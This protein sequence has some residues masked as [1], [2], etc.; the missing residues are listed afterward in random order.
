MLFLCACQKSPPV[1]APLPKPPGEAA[2]GR[3]T[4][5]TE[6]EKRLGIPDGLTRLATSRSSQRRL[7]RG[8][9]IPPPGRSAWLLAPH[10][11]FVLPTGGSSLPHASDHVQSGQVMAMLSASL[12]PTERAQISTVRVDADAQVARA[13][14]QD[15]ASELALRR[16]E[17][18]LAEDAVGTKVV[19]EAQAQ[20]DTAR[21]ALKAALA[22]QAAVVGS[23]EV[24]SQSSATPRSVLSQIQLVAPLSGRVRDVKVAARQ[25]VLAGTPLFEIVD[26]EVAWVRVSVPA[27]MI[28][29][30]PASTAAYVDAL[31]AS[32]KS[33]AV[34]APPAKQAPAT[35]NPPQATV[36]RY[37]V[38]P[39]T[40]RFQIGQSVAVWLA[41]SE[42]EESPTVQAAALL[43]DASGGTWVYQQAAPY[44]F[45]RRRV[46]VVRI[47]EG[48]ALLSNRSL[49][50][51]GLRIGDRIVTSGALE[52]FGT[53]FGGGK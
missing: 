5:S 35:A 42:E 22:Q 11:G 38:L 37:F 34:L 16:A 25:L 31:S 26:D 45:V 30:V 8:E 53:E 44:S 32:T 15:A 18:L 23:S 14:V 6:A 27:G 9:V 43:Y 20:R 39:Q 13:K 28:E 10:A 41:L 46:E 12:A 33:A 21:A 36:D 47:E 49:H 7:L 19:D 4:L 2:L 3:V 48:V 24:G 50:S 51:S 1:S 52:L 40:A 29:S 17:R